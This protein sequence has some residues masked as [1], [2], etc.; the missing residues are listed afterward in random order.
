MRGFF[1]QL[2]AEAEAI[3]KQ[4]REQLFREICDTAPAA[5]REGEAKIR[6]GNAV[7]LMQLIEPEV[8]ETA[9][10]ARSKWDVVLGGEIAVRQDKPTYIWGSS[11][12]VLQDSPER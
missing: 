12:M 11:L 5:T 7:L 9:E 10:F 1:W 6:L 8:I 3:F 4:I 2:A